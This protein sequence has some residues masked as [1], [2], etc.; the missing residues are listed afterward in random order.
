MDQHKR[1]CQQI[2]CRGIPG[3]ALEEKTHGSNN[4]SCSILCKMNYG[5]HFKSYLQS[6]YKDLISPA[7][8]TELKRQREARAA[9]PHHTRV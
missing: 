9:N 2:R 4:L 6:N 5:F 7:Q 3:D 8:E 1:V